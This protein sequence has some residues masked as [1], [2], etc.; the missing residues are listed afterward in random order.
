MRGGLVTTGKS[1][2]GFWYV[3]ITKYG[4]LLLKQS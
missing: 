1:F 2:V 3:M 4:R